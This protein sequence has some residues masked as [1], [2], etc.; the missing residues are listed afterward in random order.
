MSRDYEL[1]FGIRLEPGVSILANV[2]EPLYTTWKERYSRAIQGE[3]LVFEDRFEIEG[4]PTYVQVSVFPIIEDGE[5]I[6]AACTSRDITQSKMA[7][8]QLIEHE[9]Y[10]VAQVENTYDA[11][12]S[13]D[14]DFRILVI[15]TAMR[16]G[17]KGA[18]GVCLEVGDDIVRAV[19]DDGD[20]R[21]KWSERYR[22]ALS[23][24]SFSI[25]EGFQY[26][27]NPAYIE[28]S[29]NPIRVEGLI[30]GVACF[31]R[32][33]TAIR[34]SEIALKKEVEVKDKFFSIIAHDL[35]SPVG[36]IRELIKILN[37][38]ELKLSADQRGLILGQ[39]EEASENVYELLDKL[40]SWSLSQQKMMVVNRELLNLSEIVEESVKPYRTSAESKAIDTVLKVDDGLEVM[41]DKRS[42]IST[43]ANL[44]SNAIKF[45]EE[46]GEIRVEVLDRQEDF[47]ISVSDSGVGMDADTAGSLFNESE[48][49]TKPGTKHERGTGLGL[50]LCNEF[51]KLNG[52]EIWVESTLGEGS[53][54]FFTIPKQI[55]QS[56]SSSP[57]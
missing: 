46:L 16:E 45:T 35:K 7:Q 9:A 25:T 17:F 32:N 21:E 18:F 43:I 20:M 10:L 13:V 40:L 11:I 14:R 55:D 47:M 39:L 57:S 33:I 50:L 2:P 6:G 37:S 23:G 31:G 30:V 29:F 28:V 1:A 24:E 54:F 26:L 5:V 3:L 4:I 49:L 52:G 44:Y 38:P 8:K 12:W 22:R 42:I 19:P 15:N 51:V 56:K 27:E 53:T 41:A 34:N 48:M 36:N